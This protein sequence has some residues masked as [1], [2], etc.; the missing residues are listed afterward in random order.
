MVRKEVG[1]VLKCINDM[2]VVVYGLSC[3]VILVLLVFL[4]WSFGVINDLGLCV[5]L[6]GIV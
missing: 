2:V 1:L 6:G 4:F 3:F 5:S